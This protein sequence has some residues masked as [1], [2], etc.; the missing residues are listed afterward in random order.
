MEKIKVL[1]K[2]LLQE[3]TTLTGKNQKRFS[4]QLKT[5]TDGSLNLG[6]L[7]DLLSTARRYKHDETWIESE[8]TWKPLNGTK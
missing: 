4:D 2:E 5:K 6:D 7:I 3:I 1:A 8:S